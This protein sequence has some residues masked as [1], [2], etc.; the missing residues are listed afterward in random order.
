MNLMESSPN[1]SPI[2]VFDSGVGGLAVLKALRSRLPGES[3]IYVA[4]NGNAPYGDQSSDFILARVR[5]VASFLVS[6]G[7]KAIVVAC[8]TASV[9]AIKELRAEH[10]IPIVAMEPAIKPATLLTRSKTV[11]VLATSNTIASN[12]VAI[13]CKEH[14]ANVKILLQACP[15]LAERVDQGAFKHPE[16]LHLLERYIKP[17]IA[18]GADIIVLGCS[19]YQFLSNEIAAIAGPGVALIDASDAVARELDRRVNPVV[20]LAVVP[21]VITY[22]TSGLV[23]D[24]SSFLE[25]IGE[26]G[27]V[28]KL[29]PR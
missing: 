7:V 8:N 23:K 9:L 3:F 6:Q 16:T 1:F 19:H 17:G 13:L 10:S 20:G 27:E 18:A 26:S 14:G 29:L 21:S 12:S 22:Y 15:G 11:L 25:L 24:F 5:A 28:V 2:G 4:D